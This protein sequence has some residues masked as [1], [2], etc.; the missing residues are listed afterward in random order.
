MS[1]SR[2]LTCFEV[3]IVGAE[4]RV[5]YWDVGSGGLRACKLW[6]SHLTIADG[7]AV[8]ARKA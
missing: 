5:S 4:A 6:L 1:F 3:F 2:W 8:L 7:I